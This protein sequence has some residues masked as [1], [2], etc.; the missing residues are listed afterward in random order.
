MYNKKCF[1]ITPISSD[2]SNIR[3]AVDGIIDGV[4][5]PVLN[6]KGYRVLV[7][8][9]MYNIGSINKSIIESIFKADLIIV[10][11]TTL[12]ANVMYELGLS[13]SFRKP[14]ITL[15]ENSLERIPFDIIDQRTIFYDDTITGARILKE[16]LAAFVDD[17]KEENE[18]TNP[19]Y[20]VLDRYEIKNI[21]SSK[22][23][24]NSGEDREELNRLLSKIFNLDIEPDF[25][26]SDEEYELLNNN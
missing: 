20:D 19:V 17:I 23:G 13:H 25:I 14:T 3:K 5:E 11:L 15:M 16:T 8:H 7:A 26:P 21:V 9:R 12:N 2:E 18:I 6:E 10:N 24:K 22:I 1:L 4:I